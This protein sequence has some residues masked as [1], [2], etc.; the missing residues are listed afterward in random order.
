MPGVDAGRGTLRAP[1]AG[2]IMKGEAGVQLLVLVIATPAASRPH[3]SSPPPGDGGSAVTSSSCDSLPRHGWTQFETFPEHPNRK[4]R[5]ISIV[6]RYP[7][8]HFMIPQRGRQCTDI[9]PYR[10]YLHSSPYVCAPQCTRIL[11]GRRFH[12]FNIW[13][14][15][16][17]IFDILILR[18][19]NISIF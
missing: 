9:Q 12:C 5:D 13:H 14:C 3:A 15:Y 19:P 1:A 8:Q 10:R 17:S 4:T 16:V 18:R 7:A 6:G 2:K 11:R